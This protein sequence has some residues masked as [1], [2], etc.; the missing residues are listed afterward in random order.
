MSFLVLFRLAGV[1]GTNENY[2]CWSSG[3][4]I[5]PSQMHTGPVQ[6]VKHNIR[7]LLTQRPTADHKGDVALQSGS[8][9]L[10][11]I[12]QQ[13]RLGHSPFSGYLRLILLQCVQ[14]KDLPHV[15][16]IVQRLFF[17]HFR[18]NLLRKPSIHNKN[19]T[20]LNSNSFISGF[21]A[22]FLQK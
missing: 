9:P 1:V 8:L 12:R 18:S 3:S 2:D 13:P 7:R 5:H 6:D 19:A 21:L 17:L 22:G 10:F 15:T 20:L 4:S 16:P 11:F 14:Q